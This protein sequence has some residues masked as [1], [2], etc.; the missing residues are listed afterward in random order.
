MHGPSRFITVRTDNCRRTSAA[1]VHQRP[2]PR[3]IFIDVATG[4]DLQGSALE[5]GI[6]GRDH[7]FRDDVVRKPHRSRFT[8]KRDLVEP[9]SM[10]HQGL[11][12]A[13]HIQRL[14]N[15]PEHFRIRHA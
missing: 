5:A 9:R 15:A 12:Y 6:L 3:S 10:D 7:L 2:E 13:H 1:S 11:L 4:H 8:M 14:R